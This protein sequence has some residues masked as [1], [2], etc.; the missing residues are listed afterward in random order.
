MKT[1]LLTI[2]DMAIIS[3][4][5]EKMLSESSYVV[6]VHETTRADA[7]EMTNNEMLRKEG[8]LNPIQ[9]HE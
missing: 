6:F 8:G 1:I 2:E 4:V 7:E 3:R 9:R 5:S